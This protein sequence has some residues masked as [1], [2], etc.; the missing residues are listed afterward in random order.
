MSLEKLG[1][2]YFLFPALKRNLRKSQVQFREKLRKLRLRQYNDSLIKKR[3]ISLQRNG[4]CVSYKESETRILTQFWPISLIK[5]LRNSMKTKSP[6]P[7]PRKRNPKMQLYLDCAF[8]RRQQSAIYC[9]L[10]LPKL[11]SA[12][13][14]KW[15]KKALFMIN[16]FH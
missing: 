14:I 15:R 11:L 7:S 12:F 5:T 3:V 1:E 4:A 2:R 8:N 9:R 16:H 6:L 10:V 13:D